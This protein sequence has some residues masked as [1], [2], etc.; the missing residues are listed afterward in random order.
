MIHPRILRNLYCIWRLK[1]CDYHMNPFRV[2]HWVDD[3]LLLFDVRFSIATIYRMLD[4]RLCIVLSRLEL[5]LEHDYYVHNQW[6]SGQLR[7]TFS[8]IFLGGANYS[9]HLRSHGWVFV[10][11]SCCILLLVNRFVIFLTFTGIIAYLTGPPAPGAN[12][13]AQVVTAN[14]LIYGITTVLVVAG[15]HVIAKLCY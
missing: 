14:M 1:L 2:N 15:G 7:I 12:L 10:R 6:R 3:V 11:R 13:C 8:E 5:H 4:K 9:F